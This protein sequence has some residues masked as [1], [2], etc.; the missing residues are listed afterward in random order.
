[1]SRLATYAFYINLVYS[2]LPQ[3][4]EVISSQHITYIYNRIN[5]IK[6]HRDKN[7]LRTNL[8]GKISLFN[9][10]KLILAIRTKLISLP[11]NPTTLYH[12]DDAV[13]STL[14]SKLYDSI[15]CSAQFLHSSLLP[16]KNLCHRIYFRVN[17]KNIDN[18]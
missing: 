16:G 8:Q 9:E 11:P 1:M 17:T 3:V 15:T 5:V 6:A 10:I 7:I 12:M 4:T 2:A 13:K 18:Q 14:I